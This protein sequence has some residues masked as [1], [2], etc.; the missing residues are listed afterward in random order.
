VWCNSADT[1][2]SRETMIDIREHCDD[3]EEV[4]H[5]DM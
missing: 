1:H 4:V 3:T 5:A 2:D